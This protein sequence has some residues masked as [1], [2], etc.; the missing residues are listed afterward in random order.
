M[1]I[2]HGDDQISSRA[3]FL[4]LKSAPQNRDKQIVD[5]AGAGLTLED[6]RQKSESSSLLGTSNVI[7]LEN[8]FAARTSR[9]K[10]QIV[11]YL[12]QHEKSDIY[13]W[14]ASDVSFQLKKF[15]PSIIQKFDF[16]KYVFQ[17]LEHPNLKLLHE[18]L[19]HS[20]PEQVFALLVGHFRKLIMAKAGVGN[21]PAWQKQKLQNQVSAMSLN[22]L[23]DVYR[24][25][26]EIDFAQKSST[27]PYGLSFSLELWVSRL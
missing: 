25:L 1:L 12:N 4:D 23:L 21:F 11:D 6:L 16:P 8:I 26:L 17:F 13:I 3:R 27:L 7:F 18:T 15:S 24:H 19:A 10:T 20:A 5:L 2:L 9:E 22:R 14:E